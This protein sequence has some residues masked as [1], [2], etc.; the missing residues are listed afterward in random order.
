[1]KDPN[2][3]ADKTRTSTFNPARCHLMLRARIL[4]SFLRTQVHISSTMM[5]THRRSDTASDPTARPAHM[6]YRS[7]GRVELNTF[8]SFQSSI[9]LLCT[10]LFICTD[11]YT[12]FHQKTASR[13]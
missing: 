9:S 4:L 8:S 7:R 6:K 11:V 5:P 13:F 10:P 12:P 3:M 1:M 2:A